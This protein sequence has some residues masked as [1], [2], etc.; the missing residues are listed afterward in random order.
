[1]SKQIR[2][3]SD[4]DWEVLKRLV[5]ANQ[6]LLQSSQRPLTNNQFRDG[7]DSMAPEVYIALVPAAGIPGLDSATS[8]SGSDNPPTEGDRPGSASCN[9]YKIIDGQ[10]RPIPGLTRTV[11][12]L[13]ESTIDSDWITVQREKFG[14]WLASVGG[15][16]S[17]SE[18]IIKRGK[19]VSSIAIGSRHFTTSCQVEIWDF[20]TVTEEWSQSNSEFITMYDD[21]MIPN[22][23]SPLPSDTWVQI[24]KIGDTWFYDGHNCDHGVGTGS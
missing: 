24:V 22:S 13:S 6:N 2:V 20:N 18:V 9:I 1:M 17:S 10:L 19:T 5:A 3:I 21:G 11:Y 7:D 15:G 8:G 4:A 12:N 16:G 14:T 23:E